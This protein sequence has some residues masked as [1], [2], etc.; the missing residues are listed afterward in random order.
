MRSSTFTESY[1][2]NKK[3]SISIEPYFESHTEN[4]GLEKYGLSV[5]ESI[6]QEEQL[7]CL[8]INGVKR[9]ITG[10]NEFAPELKQLPDEERL[11]K[12]KQI[13]ITVSELEKTLG[14]KVVNPDDEN[15]WD[16]IEML[17]PTNSALWDNIKIRCGNDPIYLNP[18]TDPYDLIKLYAIEAGGFSIIAPSLEEAKRRIKPP[19]F[20]LNKIDATASNITE[21]KK[22]RNRAL[23]ELQKLYD[24]NANKLFYVAKIVDPDSAQYKKSTPA[25]ILYD[26]A[27]KYINGALTERDKRKT[28]QHFMDVCAM[29]M[30]TLKITALVKDARNY[31]FIATKGDGFIYHIE[32]NEMLGKNTSDVIEF[33]KNPLHEEV[34]K[35]L[36]GKVE[37]NWN[38]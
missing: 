17:H 11:A 9:Y 29:D 25:D 22:L 1:S 15:F 38:Q 18:A 26:N 14:A 8:E 32:R 37:K 6:M 16:K 13:R 20:Y 21:V 19:K 10:L 24:K 27:D 31:R 28:A 3:S 4:M 36:L 7:T 30:E 12:I 34:L 23:S 35:D 33:L 5:Y 2:L